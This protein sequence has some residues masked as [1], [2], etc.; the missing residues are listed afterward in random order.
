MEIYLSK[1]EV[2]REKHL[3]APRETVYV[4]EGPVFVVREYKE[5]TVQSEEEQAPLSC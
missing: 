1:E 2:E 3:F 4:L 5:Q